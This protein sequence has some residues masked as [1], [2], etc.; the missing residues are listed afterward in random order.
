MYHAVK[1]NLPQY[2]DSKA[3]AQIYF[4]TRESVRPLSLYE[5]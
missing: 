3:Y 2:W 4:L 5:T 1:I